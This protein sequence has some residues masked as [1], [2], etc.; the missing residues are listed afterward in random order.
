LNHHASIRM[1][2]WECEILRRAD[3]GLLTSRNR[4]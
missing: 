3:I 4:C 1:V 2:E